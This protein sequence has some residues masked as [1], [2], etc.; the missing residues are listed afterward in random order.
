MNNYTEEDRNLGR[1]IHDMGLHLLAFL[2]L[3]LVSLL[4]SAK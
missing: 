2:L 1:N 3:F 4:R